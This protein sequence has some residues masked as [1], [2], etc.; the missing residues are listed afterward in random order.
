MP[1]SKS[2]GARCAEGEQ[3]SERP[4]GPGPG[5]T[6]GHKRPRSQLSGSGSGH[7]GPV[8]SPQGSRP[9]SWPPPI[10]NLLG[11]GAGPTINIPDSRF[12]FSSPRASNR[13]GQVR[14]DACIV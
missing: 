4:H 5:H 11:A 13:Y 10:A 12:G 6:R 14:L 2:H 7:P 3:C 8:T 9:G 1:V